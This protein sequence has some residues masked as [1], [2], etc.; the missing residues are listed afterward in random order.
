MMIG[1]ER[2]DA[3]CI[4]WIEVLRTTGFNIQL[5]PCGLGA[6]GGVVGLKTLGV[7][8][9]GAEESGVLVIVNDMLVE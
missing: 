6:M 9:V 1:G 2:T 5:S 7:A 3:Y 8:G 4:P